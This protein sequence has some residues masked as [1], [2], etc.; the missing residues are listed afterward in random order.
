MSDHLKILASI[1]F[2]KA[3][4]ISSRLESLGIE[5][6]FKDVNAVIQQSGQIEIFVKEDDIKKANEILHEIALEMPDLTT[7]DDIA[8]TDVILVPVDFSMASLNAAYFALELAAKVKSRIKFLHTYGFPEMRPVSFDDTDF[9][10]GTLSA[11]ITEM[12]QEAETKFEDL[13]RQIQRYIVERNLGEIPISTAIING[14]PDEII[15]YTANT[16]KVGLILM[17]ISGKEVRT[18]EPIGKMAS[19]VVERAKC[20]VF[21]IPEDFVLNGI[22]QLK[23]VLYTTAFDESDFIAV[24]R[25]FKI[26]QQL[27]SNIHLLHISNAEGNT[28]DTIKMD[29]LRDYFLK[30]YNR[31]N[32]SSEVIVSK[33]ILKALDEYI[34]KNSISL[35]SVVTH[36]RNLMWK[37]MN[38]S[39]TLK[40]LYHTKIPLL[41]FHA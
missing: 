17:G 41:V 20:P 32:V 27:N 15:L 1:S 5:C 16:E 7:E 36:K 37:L 23:D 13:L 19:H 8:I 12:R 26:V 31:S 35:I 30:V 22:D 11:Y 6:F 40:I 9:Y 38:P 25:L 2:S 34:D 3:Q 24:K 29:G 10:S 18:F 14:L 21:I 33:D 4:I 39:I 28:W